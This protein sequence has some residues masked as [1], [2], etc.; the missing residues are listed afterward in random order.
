[1]TDNLALEPRFNL[2]SIHGGGASVTSYD[3]ALGVVY[4][5]AGDRVGKGF[6]GRPFIGVSGVDVSGAI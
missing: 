5:P 3:F 1:M 4:Q 6:Y 2:S